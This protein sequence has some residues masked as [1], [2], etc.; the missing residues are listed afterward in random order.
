MPSFSGQ[1][2]LQHSAL[3]GY[4]FPNWDWSGEGVDE[5]ANFLLANTPPKSTSISDPVK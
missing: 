5:E 2:L 4:T 1:D 3:S